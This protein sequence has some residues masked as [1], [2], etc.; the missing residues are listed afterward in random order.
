[1]K[2]L[3][4]SQ[5]RNV[6]RMTVEVTGI[7]YLAL[8]E[9]AGVSVVR[10]VESHLV[11]PSRKSWRDWQFLVFCGRGNN[12][13]D[14][15]VVARQLWLRG[16]GKVDVYLAGR[17]EEMVG[18]ARANMKI[19]QSI[20]TMDSVLSYYEIDDDLPLLSGRG[21]RLV[22][23]DAIF[24]TGLN[25]Q[26]GGLPAT[27]I[28]MINRLRDE[29]AIV[30][31]IDLPSGLD[32]D[33]G[34]VRE[35]HVRADLTVSL[36]APKI[37][38]ILHPA[39][40]SNGQLLVAPIGTPTCLL[41]RV[42]ESDECVEK[43]GWLEVAEEDWVAKWLKMSR[44]EVTAH[45]GSAG[46]VLV[47]AGAVGR[48]GA[49]AL[50]ASGVLR[51]GAGLVTVGTPVSAL[52]LLVSQCENEV[53]AIALPESPD[54]GF[55]ELSCGQIRS[56][57]LVWDVLAIGPGIRS[58]EDGTRRFVEELI[59]LSVGPVVIDADGLNALAPWPDNLVGR[60]DRPIIITPHPGE[61]ARL[62]GLSIAEVQENRV[63]VARKMAVLH[64]LIVVLKG[65]G[66]VIA[67]PTGR[68]VINPTGN[69]GMATAG[70]GDVLTGIIAGLLAQRTEPAIEAV[71]AGVWL[72]GQAGDL[73]AS[74]LGKRYLLASD[75]RDCVGEAIINTGGEDERGEGAGLFL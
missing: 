14:G 51:S 62:T 39:A 20:A 64:Q 40:S 75:I 11:E 63:E 45:K 44:R 8:M 58:E 43:T 73:A 74:R 68:V 32:S 29:G 66:T 28:K 27:M 49:A 59:E 17:P 61:M 37:A 67:D 71:I 50:T 5:M 30:V 56:S 10:A 54:G 24:G 70:A 48:T 41:D 42:V 21:E 55:S 47:I 34:A 22:V 35:P 38:N 19:V 1:M 31:S 36:T 4:A 2:V 53:M 12:G 25:R 3:T 52:P 33:S 72:H 18:E 57:R 13:G 23:I 6:D 7:S 15:A 65:A 9:T 26:V 46:R 16:V 60:A 69:E